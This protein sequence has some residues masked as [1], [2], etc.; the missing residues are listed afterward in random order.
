MAKQA[1]EHE[2]AMGSF[3]ECPSTEVRRMDLGEGEETAED[4]GDVEGA[5]T[6]N[7]AKNAKKVLGI[8]AAHSVPLN[9]GAVCNQ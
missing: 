3:V 4:P 5:P 8:P 7:P 2:Q 1:N 6:L 9:G